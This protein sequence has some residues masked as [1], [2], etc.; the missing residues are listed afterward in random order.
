MNTKRITWQPLPE[1]RLTN[2][3]LEPRV[4]FSRQTKGRPRF[5]INGAAAKL[6]R[7]GDGAWVQLAAPAPAEAN[8]SPVLGL[9]AM[10]EAK[11]AV[12]VRGTKASGSLIFTTSA[13]EE[14]RRKYRRIV[15][16]PRAGRVVDG[17]PQWVLDPV[18]SDKSP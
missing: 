14:L 8:G 11:G 7:L 10:A 12:R 3:M 17:E 1:P 9:R 18:E 15:Y 4:L 13:V 6:M 16:R 5:Y 2:T